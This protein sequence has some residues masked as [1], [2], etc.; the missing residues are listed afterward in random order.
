MAVMNLRFFR[1]PAAMRL[2]YLRKVGDQFFSAHRLPQLLKRIFKN[3]T[4]YLV[5]F[6]IQ[7]SLF[8]GVIEKILSHQDQINGNLS[9]WKMVFLRSFIRLAKPEV[10][11]ETGVAHGSSS[12]VI[13]DALHQNQRGKLYS[14]DLPI[15]LSSTGRMTPWLQDYSFHPDDVS[16][17]PD[18]DQVGW[19]VPR[20][21]HDRWELLLGNSLVELP[22][23]V[24]TLGQIDL[25]FHDSLHLYE[26]MMQEFDMVWPFLKSGGFIL[27]DDIF[28]RDHPVI[29][30]F[31]RRNGLGFKNFLEV[32]IIGKKTNGKGLLQNSMAVKDDQ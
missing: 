2:S 12:A 23:L 7:E 15:A 25:F 20:Q 4:G 14:I 28:I 22:K 24:R 30:D 11:V 9:K 31:A 32:G 8:S 3:E 10:V 1:L 29:H 13:L 16:V 26:H 21:F 6:I 17:V 5:E 18:F 27:S 19:L